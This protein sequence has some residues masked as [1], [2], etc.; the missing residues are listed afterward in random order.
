MF[1]LSGSALAAMV[2]ARQGGEPQADVVVK[3]EGPMT[4]VYLL[5]PLT[6]KADRWFKKHL[7]SDA[8]TLGRSVAVEHRFVRDIVDGMRRSKLKVIR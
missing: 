8:P 2:T 6:A 3:G 7:P 4:T 1:N 5:E